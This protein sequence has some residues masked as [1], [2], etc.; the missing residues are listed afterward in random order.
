MESIVSNVNSTDLHTSYFK[1]L[2]DLA[3]ELRQPTGVVE[4]LRNEAMPSLNLR[5][6]KITPGAIAKT[7]SIKVG[8][9]DFDFGEFGTMVATIVLLGRDLLNDPNPFWLAA[10]VVLI[11]STLY[12]A[13]TKEIAQPEATVFWG[14]IQAADNNRFSTEAAIRNHTNFERNKLGLTPLTKR[15]IESALLQLK[16]IHCVI[17]IDGHPD[18]WQIIEKYQIIP[19]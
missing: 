2:A 1:A 19:R 16:S 9:I 17:P 18:M 8:N 14:F 7:T 10:G 4:Q 15:Q 13:S 3:E 6:V 12:K 11:A 5:V